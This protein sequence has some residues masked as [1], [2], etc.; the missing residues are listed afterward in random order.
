M[1]AHDHA[2]AAPHQVTALFEP[3]LPEGK[4][5]EGLWPAILADTG[6]T[7]LVT[8]NAMRLL[9]T[10][11]CGASSP[12]ARPRSTAAGSPPRRGCSTSLCRTSNG[13]AANLTAC[14]GE[15][16]PVSAAAKAAALAF[17]VF[18]DAP[19]AEAEILALWAFD[20][21]LA[22]RLRW[23]RPLPLIAMRILDPTLRRPE[24]ARPR[25][26]E[27]AWRSTPPG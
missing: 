7:V 8:A 26:G 20:L 3:P 15:G 17:S 1:S 27:P 22:I 4:A 10:R 18:P 9:S 25:P 23:P 6:A 19:A 13:V 21:T 11:A 5:R 14:A 12:L 16:D 24:A 2:H